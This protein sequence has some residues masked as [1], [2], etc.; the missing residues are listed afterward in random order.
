MALS[1]HEGGTVPAMAPLQGEA[2]GDLFPGPHAVIDCV[3]GGTLLDPAHADVPVAGGNLLGP[4]HV[5]CAGLGVAGVGAVFGA[6]SQAAF[7]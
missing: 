3:V 6:F 1:P 4:A 2:G 7:D 5:G